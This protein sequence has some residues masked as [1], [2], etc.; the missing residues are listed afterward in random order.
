M[1][2]PGVCGLHFGKH[3]FKKLKIKVNYNKLENTCHKTSETKETINSSTLFFQ[4][5]CFR[6]P[7]G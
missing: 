2:T 1:G 6:I 4:K 5:W 7:T 3:C